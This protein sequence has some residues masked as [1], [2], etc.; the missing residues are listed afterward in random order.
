MQLHTTGWNQYLKQSTVWK[1]ISS[2]SFLNYVTFKVFDNKSYL[3]K[4]IWNWI[5]HKGWYV[6]KHNQ[7]KPF[8]L[9]PSK[10]ALAHLNMYMCLCVCICMCV[11]VCVCIYTIMHYITWKCWYA[12]KRNHTQPTLLLL[13]LLLKHHDGKQILRSIL[14][15]IHELSNMLL[16]RCV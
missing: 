13:L 10:W 14:T 9:C 11:C 12:I 15:Y 16:G 7:T 3:Y 6:I 1:E 4:R 2:D 8:K 5:A